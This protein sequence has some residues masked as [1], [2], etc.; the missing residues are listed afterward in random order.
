VL[1]KVTNG[2]GCASA[3]V[4]TAGLAVLVAMTLDY[5]LA[6]LSLFLLPVSFLL[7]LIA[8]ILSGLGASQPVGRP[9]PIAVFIVAL[10]VYGSIVLRLAGVLPW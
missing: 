1:T 4:L 8:I 6:M 7:G 10:G 5:G 9:V 3:L 2:Y